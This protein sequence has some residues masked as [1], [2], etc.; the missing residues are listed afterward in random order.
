MS[1]AVMKRGKAAAGADAAAEA[2]VMKKPDGDWVKSSVK[3]ADLEALRAQGLLPPVDQAAVR[4]PGKEVF[5]APR[6]GERVCF[7]DFLPRGF[8]F[9]LHDFVRGLLYAY[10]IQIHDLTP[11]SVLSIASYFVLCECFLGI[12]PNWL[13]WK[14]L[15]LVRRNVGKSKQV[16][17]VGGFGIQVRG[18]TSYFQM[19]KSDSVQGWRKKWFYI[20]CDQA[21]LPEFAADRELRKT[22]AWAHPLSKEDREATQPLLTL[23]R[24]LLKS[25]GRETGGIHLI[26]TFFRL[27]VQPLRSRVHPMWAREDAGNELDDD[28]VESK[29][30]S[31]TSLRAADPCNVKCPV[32]PYG[33]NN[34]VPEVSFV[35]FVLYLLLSNLFA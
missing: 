2:S 33:P 23:L 34:P 27:R 4:A 9:P 11:N 19:K 30:R 25:L 14:S 32:E 35:C 5:P 1:K 28:A 3:K 15:F 31:I 16:Y 20:R 26:A 21:G 22:N 24:G 29:V 7:V 12:A 13:L 8:G 17:P 10:G 6:E 18:D